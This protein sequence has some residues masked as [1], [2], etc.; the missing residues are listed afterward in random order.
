MLANGGINNITV[1]SQNTYPIGGTGTET[2]ADVSSGNTKGV[3]NATNSDCPW[4]VQ[5]CGL[6]DE[7]SSFHVGG[8]NAVFVD[9]SVR[10]LNSSLDPITMRRLVTRSEGIELPQN[11]TYTP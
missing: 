3:M 10:F 6:N 11:T 9:G 7:P 5:N 8:C 1:I 2:T 4:I